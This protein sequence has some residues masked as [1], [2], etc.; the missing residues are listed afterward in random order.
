MSIVKKYKAEIISILN[1]LPEIYTIELSSL[2]GKFRYL[3]GQFLHLALD[4]YDPS[5]GWPESRCF[6]MQSSPENES[7]KITFSVKGKYTR[8]MAE[9]LTIS[10]ILDIK[11]PYGN[12]FQQDHS[13]E[14]VVFIAGGTGITPFLSLFGDSSFSAYEKPKLYFGVRE[15][16]Y[17]LYDSDLTRA[18]V[19]NHGLKTSFFKGLID[20][21]KIINENSPSSTYFISGPQSMISSFRFRLKSSGID[22]QLIRTD[23]WE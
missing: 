8:R 5:Y 2:S 1:P 3:P 13:K 23:D 17:N 20:I 22:E 21:E 9:E 4:E 16:K 11:L 7:I 14:D 19:L 12:L 18:L 6:S 15:Q 10:K